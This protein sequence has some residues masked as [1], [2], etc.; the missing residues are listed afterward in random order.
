MENTTVNPG[1]AAEAAE[2]NTQTN[3]GEQT[4]SKTY[5]Q[6]EV[7]KL[8]QAES[9][10]RVNQA[11]KTF[12]EKELPGLLQQAQAEAEK[13]AKMTAEQKAQHAQAQKEQALAERE[14]ALTRK[15]LKAEARDTLAEKGLPVSLAELLPC[16]DADS[17]KKGLEALEKA[18]RQAVSDAV[19]ARLRQSPPK[20]GT[21]QDD[22]TP[23]L[24]KAAGLN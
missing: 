13:L 3:P 24:R 20:A 6:E 21:H 12:K 4:E 2:Q 8:L 1:A 15:E 19:D 18:F 17:C 5:S 11:L 10:R 16:E 23:A 9:D 22:L 7:N 14:Q